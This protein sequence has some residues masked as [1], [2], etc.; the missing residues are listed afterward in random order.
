MKKIK[1]NLR[2]SCA[3]QASNVSY[4][5]IE[6]YVSRSLQKI[7]LTYIYYNNKYNKIKLNTR[8]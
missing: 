8:T 4:V 3:L 6:D 1:T 5:K 7:K 2:L